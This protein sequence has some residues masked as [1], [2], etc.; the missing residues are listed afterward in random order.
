MKVFITHPSGNNFVR[1]LLV[2]LVNDE[3]LAEFGTAIA[4]DPKA[5][6]LKLMPE[7]MRKELLRR[8]FD[9]SPELLWTHSFRETCRMIF[10]KTGLNLFTRHEQGWASVDAVYQDFDY[11]A[12]Q[13][14]LK[15]YKNVDTVYA[16][17]DGALNTF[18]TA[19]KLGIKCVYD[20]PIVYWETN[21]KLI[22]EEADRLP[23]WIPALGGGMKDSEE[24]LNRKVQELELADVVV[25][26]SKFVMD[27]LPEKLVGNKQ[28][29]MAPFGSPKILSDNNLPVKNTSKT[30]KPLRV[31][32]V[33]SMTQ[34]K[35]LGD[36]FKAVELINS[37]AIEL[38]AMGSLLAPLEF[39]KKQFSD[40]T[41]EAGRPHDQVLELMRSCDIFC[42]PSIAEGRAL[43]MQEA[44]SQGLPLIITPNT[45]GA[46]L[47]IEGE[48][49]FLVPIRSPE[50]I[51]DRLNWFLENRNEIPRMGEK[52]RKHSANYT[53]ENY[54]S[55]IVDSI[56]KC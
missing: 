9:V 3:L 46:D 35:G 21:R 22:M 27:S 2:K 39:Y 32:F 7:G 41:Y 19:K 15:I 25:C 28:L 50:A 52:A 33:G 36:L 38:V 18:K 16:Y 43:V 1:A 48:T 49:G 44:M 40:F 54:A 10:T 51:A 42:L 8:Y 20:L 29:I 55:T 31:L 26:P 17:D 6:F 45:G 4:I 47:I 5:F 56:S 37:S 34:R 53:W 30:N 23:E 12:A 24:K 11:A 13:H 14:L